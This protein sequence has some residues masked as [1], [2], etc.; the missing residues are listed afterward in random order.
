MRSV[1]TTTT[2]LL[3]ALMAFVMTVS[4]ISAGIIGGGSGGAGNDDEGSG[5]GGTGRFGGLGGSG[6]G[7]SG[8]GGTGYRPALGYDPG[9]GEIRLIEEHHLQSI[10]RV[11][12]DS[13]PSNEILPLVPALEEFTPRLVPLPAPLAV[14]QLNARQLAA[15]SPFPSAPLP[16]SSEIQAQWEIHAL[17]LAMAPLEPWSLDTSEIPVAREGGWQTLADLAGEPSPAN[18]EDR[19]QLRTAYP[20]RIQRPD[21]P[22]IQRARPVERLSILPPRVQPMRI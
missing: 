18:S 20:D 6:G 17:Q 21:L 19:A 3:A 2:L 15:E 7:E 12:K 16:V 1:D 10:Q 14:P 4:N 8:F 11:K 22:P 9:T 13:L 5:I